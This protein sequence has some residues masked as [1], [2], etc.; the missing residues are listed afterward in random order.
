MEN[1]IDPL[2]KRFTV[3]TTNPYENSSGMTSDDFD[4]LREDLKNYLIVFQQSCNKL[5]VSLPSGF[6]AAGSQIDFVPD[7][8]LAKYEL[9]QFISGKWKKFPEDPMAILSGSGIYFKNTGSPAKTNISGRRSSVLQT[10]LSL[11]WN[12]L[13]SPYSS[14]LSDLKT[15]IENENCKKIV[16]LS[17][18]TNLGGT[19]TYASKMVPIIDNPTAGSAK[20]AFKYLGPYDGD[21]ILK[22]IPSGTNYWF[23]LFKMPDPLNTDFAL[24]PCLN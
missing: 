2:I 16:P 8:K 17:I 22:K 12:L 18:L 21:Q 1:Q 10:Q 4:R 15:I 24:Y 5:S 20:E 14:D 13:Y 6:N 3:S 9:F 23:Y 11:G 19:K 7:A